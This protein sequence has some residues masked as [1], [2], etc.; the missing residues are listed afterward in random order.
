MAPILVAITRLIHGYGSPLS[1]EPIAV[2]TAPIS[3]E[4]VGELTVRERLTLWRTC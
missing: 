1:T 3:C 4:S 2:P